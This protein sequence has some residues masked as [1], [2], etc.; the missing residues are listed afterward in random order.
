MTIEAMGAQKQITEQIVDKGAEYVLALK[1]NQSTFH[2]DVKEFFDYTHQ[3]E[4]QGIPDD[5][6]RIFGKDHGSFET[7]EYWTVSDLQWLEEKK[8]WKG[9]GKKDKKGKIGGIPTSAAAPRWDN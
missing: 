8:D 5:Y 6:Y 9:D 2:E 7:R 3:R 1:G 4:F